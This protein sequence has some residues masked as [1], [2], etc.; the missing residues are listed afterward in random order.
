M[1]TD[2]PEETST[3][4]ARTAPAADDAHKP[5]GPADLAKPTWTYI[6]KRTLR[7]F[8]KDQC[9]DAAAA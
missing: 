4:K 7:E 3:V 1:T 6:A 8:G 5:A 2:E 9:P